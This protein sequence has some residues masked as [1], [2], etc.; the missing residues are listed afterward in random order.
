LLESP[1]FKL[2]WVFSMTEHSCSWKLIRHLC[3]C[4]V[5]TSCPFPV[6]WFTHFS[7][8]PCIFQSECSL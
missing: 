8:A 3:I 1:V 5:C 4:K 6:S 7:Y 2:V